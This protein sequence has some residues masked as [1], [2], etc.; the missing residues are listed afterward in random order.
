MVLHRFFNH[1]NPVDSHRRTVADPLDL[2]DLPASFYAENIART[3]PLQIDIRTDQ[4]SALHST[5]YPL[6][7]TRPI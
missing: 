3:F 7:T 2:V 1:V 5:V 4:S 6:D